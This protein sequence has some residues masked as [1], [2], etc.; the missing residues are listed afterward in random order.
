MR[1]LTNNPVA[2]PLIATS[3]RT[4]ERATAKLA[5]NWGAP[6][7]RLPIRAHSSGQ[8]GVRTEARLEC[9]Y[10]PFAISVIAITAKEHSISWTECL[11]YLLLAHAGKTICSHG[12]K[13]LWL[14]AINYE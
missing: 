3:L 2:Q 5:Q 12:Q 13:R 10:L 9:C 8:E 14:D 1:R 6:L 11:G 7:A 4:K